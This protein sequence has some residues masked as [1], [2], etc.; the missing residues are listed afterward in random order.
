[1]HTATFGN[2]PHA[3]LGVSDRF[4]ALNNHEARMD[5]IKND[6]VCSERNAHFLL[7]AFFV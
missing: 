1:M 5:S 2:F 3:L 7:L 6:N 4:L